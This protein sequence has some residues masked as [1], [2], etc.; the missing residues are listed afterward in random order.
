ML[1]AGTYGSIPGVVTY[2]LI[3]LSPEGQQPAMVVEFVLVPSEN[4]Q[5]LVLPNSKPMFTPFV[6]EIYVL[7]KIN[8][9]KNKKNV[10]II[11][12]FESKLMQSYIEF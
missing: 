5:P 7:V 8:K 6:C 1:I 12:E 4:V 3:E 11:E 10:F 9:P 2:A